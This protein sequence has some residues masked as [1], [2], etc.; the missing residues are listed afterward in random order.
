MFLENVVFDAVQPRTV[1]QFW[2]G[3]LDL[4]TLTD[5]DAG[6]E[7]RF[8]VPDGPLLDLCFQQVGSP[9]T[10]PSRLRL[11]V[12]I[13]RTHPVAG[14]AADP[15]GNPYVVAD[16]AGDALLVGILLEVADVDRDRDFWSW[17]TGWQP[18]A[19][20][21]S[22]RLSHPSG[23]GP[24]LELVPEQA[25]KDGKNRIHLDL[26]LEPGDDPDEIARQISDHGGREFH[27]DWG[28]LPWRHFQDP[29]GNEFCV[30]RAPQ[31]G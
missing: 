3:V 13:T 5:E 23:K 20:A 6:Y 24:V 28:D 2:E 29:S 10:G 18:V 22:G 25:P 26:R 15:E 12:A 19:D 11:E 8:E 27:P 7:T 9:P 30:L 1:G 17:L 31:G 4:E 21:G 14:P 16:R